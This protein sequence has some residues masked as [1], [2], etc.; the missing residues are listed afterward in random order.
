MQAHLL[1]GPIR[2]K[3][4]HC[5]RFSSAIAGDLLPPS[6]NPFVRDLYHHLRRHRDGRFRCQ[7]SR[8]KTTVTSAASSSSSSSWGSNTGV[9][10]HYLV[11]GVARNATSVDIKKAYRLL[12]RKFHPDVNKD[13]RAGERFKSIRCSYEVLSNEATRS[14]YDRAL[15]FQEDSRFSK[16]NRHNYNTP[17]VEDAVKYSWSEK[18]RQSRYGRFHGHYSTYPNSHFYSEPQAGEETTQEQRDSFAKVVRSFFL[19]VFLLYT[20]G[21]LASLTF[22][23]FTALLDKE[24]DMG[25]K[26]GFVTAWILGGKGGILLTLCLT[27]ASW[28]CGKAS[29]GVVVLVVV[30]MWVGSSLARHAPLPHGALLTLLYMSIKLQLDST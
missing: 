24:L 3:G 11:L 4:C 7:R 30:A 22:S 8:R 16:V 21:C 17:E 13:T 6:F 20:L 26:L 5:R 18:R 1:L 28:L 15:K 12:A 23:T 14:Q 29:S 2:I 25:Y 9:Q 10:D 19:S 27:F